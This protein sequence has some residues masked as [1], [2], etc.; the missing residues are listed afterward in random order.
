M[1]KIITIICLIFLLLMPIIETPTTTVQEIIENTTC[2]YIVKDVDTWS[3][4]EPTEYLNRE[5]IEITD[6]EDTENTIC[7]FIELKEN[8]KR[9]IKKA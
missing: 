1:V 6:C 5:V 7:I 4:L 8:E 9:I 3:I 2:D